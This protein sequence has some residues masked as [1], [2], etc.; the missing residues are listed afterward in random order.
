M[1]ILNCLTPL[2]ADDYAWDLLMG[3]EIHI[4]NVNDIVRSMYNYYFT[5]GGRIGGAFYDQ[6][7]ML[8]GKPIFNI[9]NTIIYII[10]TLLIYHICSEKRR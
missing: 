9:C 6:L 10:N 1:Y 8:L 3:T 4:N 2:L 5:W 7:F